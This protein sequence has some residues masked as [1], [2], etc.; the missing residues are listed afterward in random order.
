MEASI[1]VMLP[2][3]PIHL[4]AKSN[5]NTSGSQENRYKSSI[6]ANSASS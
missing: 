2:I 5:E 3:I 1:Y 4:F 6:S